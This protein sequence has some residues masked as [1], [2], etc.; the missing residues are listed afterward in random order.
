M[1]ISKYQILSGTL[2]GYTAS[3]ISGKSWDE[4]SRSFSTACGL[5]FS[6]D[7]SC[8]VSKGRDGL[9]RL[10][11]PKRAYCDAKVSLAKVLSYIASE[12]KTDSKCGLCVR[13]GY[14]IAGSDLCKLN[15]CKF[16]LGFDEESSYRM[17]PERKDKIGSKSIYRKYPSSLNAFG[18][19]VY[20]QYLSYGDTDSDTYGVTFNNLKANEIVFKYIGGKGY[21][22]E[23]GKIS[24]LIDY[25]AVYTYTSL[26]DCDYNMDDM[27]KLS[28]L[29]KKYREIADAFESY[30]K[31]KERFGKIELMVDLE[32]M[33]GQ[34]STYWGI[35]KERLYEIVVGGMVMDGEGIKI[36]YDTDESIFQLKDAEVDSVLS[37]NGID[38]IDCNI[39]GN[40][41]NCTVYD[42]V[43]TN[44][45][46]TNSRAIGSCDITGCVVWTTYLSELVECRD[47]TIGGDSVL[48]GL[49]ENCVLEDGV[50]YTENATLKKCKKGD[51]TEIK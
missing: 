3:F 24:H 13:I 15:V 36:N 35:L 26:V 14:D 34:E 31:F 9:Y 33:D 25:Y 37:L 7:N 32:P 43:V 29:G 8:E 6:G 23:W 45:A 2:V 11:V 46:I 47:C 28:E 18:D 51:L 30:G 38:I 50:S 40:I 42:S 39:S 22:K 48:C 21:E 20:S 12:Y 49:A 44:S 27:R 4:V 41:D 1:E 17:F 16:I 19:N 5:D 10:T